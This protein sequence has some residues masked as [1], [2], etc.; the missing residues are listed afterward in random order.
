MTDVQASYFLK[1]FAKHIALQ[2]LAELGRNKQRESLGGKKNL[3]LS[4]SKAYSISIVKIKLLVISA[5][6]ANLKKSVTKSC[7]KTVIL[8]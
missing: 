4:K 3:N 2:I 1:V 5:L 7:S 8:K 6:S